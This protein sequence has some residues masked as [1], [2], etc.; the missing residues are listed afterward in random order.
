MASKRGDEAKRR[1]TDEQ[2]RLL[3]IQFFSFLTITSKIVMQYFSLIFFFVSIFTTRISRK[4]F[5]NPASQKTRVNTIVLQPCTLSNAKKFGLKNE[6]VNE[7]G[8]LS[9]RF[10]VIPPRRVFS[11]GLRLREN[12]LR[13]KHLVLANRTAQKKDTQ[14]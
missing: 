8:M 4:I 6:Y 13:Y 7:I 5:G 9:G 11:D 1:F 10:F 3:T 14:F 12:R 2:Q